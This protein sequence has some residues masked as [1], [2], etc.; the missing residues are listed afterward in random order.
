MLLKYRSL[1]RFAYLNGSK[2]I[3][4]IKNNFN[5]GEIRYEKDRMERARL[6]S[7][8]RNAS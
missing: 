3:V 5:I 7:A 8:L 6:S 2:H 1:Y 4:K